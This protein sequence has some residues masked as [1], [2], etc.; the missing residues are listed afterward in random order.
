M[1]YRCRSNFLEFYQILNA[2]PSYLKHKA[3]NPGQNPMSKCCENWTLF[4]LDEATQ[5]DL[6][7][8][9]VRDNYRLLLVKKHLSPPTGPERWNKDFSIDRRVEGT[10][11]VLPKLCKDSKLKEF[12]YNLLYGLL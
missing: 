11:C 10:F 1:E 8:F 5:I 9:K 12:Q 2:I 7:K 4:A 6:E 3:R